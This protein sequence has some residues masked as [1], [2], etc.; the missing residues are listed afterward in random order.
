MNCSQL[1]I[2]SSNINTEIDT[3]KT[4]ITNT[5]YID[6]S[7]ATNK[8]ESDAFTDSEILSSKAFI[9]SEVASAKTEV[10]TDINR[11]TD[12]KLA[13]TKSERVAYT[14]AQVATNKTESTAYTDSKFA[15]VIFSF[16]NDYIASLTADLAGKVV[17]DLSIMNKSYIDAKEQQLRNSFNNYHGKTDDPLRG[18][19]KADSTEFDSFTQTTLKRTVK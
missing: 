16:V 14:D 15:T 12:T 9:A 11:S 3:I 19:H 1:F 5:D 7:I 8:V 10:Q 18:I 2:G 17:S 4:P 6:N 13:T